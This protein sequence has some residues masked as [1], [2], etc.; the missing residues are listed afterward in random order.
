MKSIISTLFC[1]VFGIVIAIPISYFFQSNIYEFISLESYFMNFPDSV[2]I[3]SR[4][5][6]WGIFRN[7]AIITI[8]ITVIVVNGFKKLY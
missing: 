4:F 3:G 7:T 5:G 6:S 1:C 2:W 8:L